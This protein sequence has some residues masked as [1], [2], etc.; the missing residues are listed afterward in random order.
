MA[1][2]PSPAESAIEA[3][4]FLQTKTSIASSEK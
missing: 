1:G 3:A 2:T 4:W